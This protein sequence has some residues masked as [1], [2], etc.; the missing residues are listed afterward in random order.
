MCCISNPWEY[1]VIQMLYH[2]KNLGL[3]VEAKIHESL[4]SDF[5][6][7]DRAGTRALPQSQVKIFKI[8]C[9]KAIAC[10]HLSIP[11]DCSFS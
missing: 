9:L 6:I 11:P 7:R 8:F 10:I 5:W 3:E 1:Y 2:S 4:V